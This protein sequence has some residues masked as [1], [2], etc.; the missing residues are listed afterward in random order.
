MHDI[1]PSLAPD[2]AVFPGDTP[3]SREVSRDTARGD[4]LTLSALRATVHLGAHADA[5][6]HYGH[7]APTMDQV[8]LARY[9]GPCRVLR[10]TAS[11]GRRLA[12]AD[13]ENHD[14]RTERLLIATG[15]YPDPSTFTP[16][17]AGLE[18]VLVDW[19]HAHGVRLVG[20][21][22]PSVDD[23]NDESLVAHR[24]FLANGM[25]ILEGLRL[26]DVPPGDY[27][28]IALPLKLVG[29]DGSP[30]R[31]ILRQLPREEP[32]RER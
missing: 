22:T 12:I 9:I 5:P 19:L 18:P 32:P 28:L 24:R 31:A 27:E 11:R 20:V 3:L 25:L 23:A 21:D 17:F 16:D 6:S 4:T 2:L 8:D 1:S 13:L 26:D 14:V 30:V 29:F 10:V 15:T 7:G